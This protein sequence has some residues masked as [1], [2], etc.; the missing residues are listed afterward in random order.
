MI[1]IDESTLLYILL[2]NRYHVNESLI[3]KYISEVYSRCWDELVFHNKIKVQCVVSTDSKSF[4]FLEKVQFIKEPTLFR[5]YICEDS[6]ND[7]NDQRNTSN[8]PPLQI[9]FFPIPSYAEEILH[10]FDSDDSTITLPKYEKIAV[11]GTFDQLHN[12]HR[13]LLTLSASV[14]SSLTVGILS[15]VLLTKKTLSS[16]IQRYPDRRRAVENFLRLLKPTLDVFCCELLDPF[17][18]TITDPSYQ[19][20]CV[21]SETISGALEI[22][23]RRKEKGYQKL[24]ILVVKR[25]DI[26]TLSSTFLRESKRE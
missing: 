16:L 25:S 10:F 2:E 21:S 14:C 5:A 1:E 23:R 17:G 18:P 26:S 6:A 12:G 9:I 20:I 24:E 13:K 11:G 3:T 19:A 8:L 4:G 15:D 7:L 22:N